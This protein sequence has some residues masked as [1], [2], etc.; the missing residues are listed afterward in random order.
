M[1]IEQ[2]TRKRYASTTLVEE[3]SYIYAWGALSVTV[4]ISSLDYTHDIHVTMSKPELVAAL[5][6]I[7]DREDE[8][9]GMRTK[10]RFSQL[11]KI[12]QINAAVNFALA[13]EA[14]GERKHF[15]IENAIEDLEWCDDS[16]RPYN[17]IPKYTIEGEDA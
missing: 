11:S 14:S 10:Y 9:A 12:A 7:T 2:V 6:K 4:A 8:I 3:K 5:K 17:E 15:N 1:K 16:D 13:W